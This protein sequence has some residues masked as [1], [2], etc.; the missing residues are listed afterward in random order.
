MDLSEYAESLR[1]ELTSITRFAG[2]DIAR[3]AE[4][5]SETLD[6]SVRLALLDVLSAAA[7]EITASLEGATIDVRLSGTEPQF[8]VNMTRPAEDPV[9]DTGDAG[10]E[11]GSSRITLRLSEGLKTRVEAAAVGA[12][13]SVNAWLVRAISRALDG[14]SG[15]ARARP[16]FPP[17][18][19]PGRPGKRFTGF[20]RS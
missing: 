17:P 15:G 19:P 3:A 18:P 8:V 4:M 14:S 5:L 9:A 10:E 6:S 16:P 1:R 12:G 20:A 2:E 7:D 11:A 13:M